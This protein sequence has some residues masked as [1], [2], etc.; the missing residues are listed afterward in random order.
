LNPILFPDTVPN[1]LDTTKKAI[2]D[3]RRVLVELNSLLATRTF[4][5]RDRLTLADIAVCAALI[6]G[7]ELVLDPGFRKAFK[8]TN[9][10]F[11]T[12][13]NQPNFLSVFGEVNL[14]VKKKVAPPPPK[15][16]EKEK[17]K[18]ALKRQ[19]ELEKE[20]KKKNAELEAKKKEEEGDEEDEA[21][22]PKP[23]KKPFSTLPKSDFNMNEFKLKYSNEDTRS[24][25]LPYFYDVYDPEGWNLYFVE[26]KYPEDLKKPLF[27]VSNL[28]GGFCQ[29]VEGI[30]NFI[31]GSLLIFGEDN[32]YHIK[33]AI[34]LRGKEWPQEEMG[35]I[36]DTESYNFTP[37]NLKNAEE[38]EF[39]EDLW[40]WDGK[41][42][43]LTFTENGKVM[44]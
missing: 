15:N 12:C 6:P 23:R 4:L 9:R 37:V 10:W 31:F 14:C 36:P 41:L 40:A 24:V 27:M 17:E 16:E 20:L 44:K 5:V 22:P 7:Y 39:F 33:G 38:K 30:R 13:M 11:L 42:R 8:N 26:Y 2:G 21:P 3:V 1:N 32:E 18:E 35:E 34:L 25:A 28:L 19:Q 43:G 29:R